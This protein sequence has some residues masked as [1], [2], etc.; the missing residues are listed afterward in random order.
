MTL[1]LGELAQ[2]LEARLEGDGSLE[3]SKLNEIEV[4]A[5]DEIS[6]ISNSK[7]LK[8]AAN[9]RAAALIVP[10]DLEIEFPN[11]LRTSNPK[12][13]MLKALQLLN[14]K[15]RLV[16]PG[17]HATAVVHPSVHV[18]A[19]AEIGSG[20]FIDEDV[21]LGENI[22]IE[23]NT[24]I[25][26]GCVLGDG[27]RLYPNVVLYEDSVLGQ[28]CIIHSCTV[29]GSDGFGF[30]VEDGIIEKIPQTGNVILGDNVEVGANCAIDCGSIGPTIIGDG[31]KLDNQI[32]IAHNVRIGKNCFLTAQVA[33]AGS[34][35]LGDRVQMGGQ[36]GIIGHLKIGNDVSIATRGGV[37]HDIPDGTMVSGFPA[38]SHRDE[39]KIEAILKKLP[40]LYKSVKMLEKQVNKD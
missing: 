9:T 22:I 36:S 34:T 3:I 24:V 27:T 39:L 10:E 30:A 5:S 11:L 29:I 17:V 8:F 21:K 7:Y 6:F 20:V 2:A 13:A 37:T 19:S 1:K 15:D 33:I 25:G 38:R 16:R 12:Q 14:H 31:T 18:P 35:E 23:A 40:E 26:S 32:H 4:A 28:N